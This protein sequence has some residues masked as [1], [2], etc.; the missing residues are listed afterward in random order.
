MSR[1]ITKRARL[2]LAVP[3]VCLA[4]CAVDPVKNAATGAATGTEASAIRFELELPAAV[5]RQAV[6]GRV[7][8]T[9]S[10][11]PGNRARLQRSFGHQPVGPGR[12]VPFFAVDIEQLQPGAVAVI[13]GDTLGYPHER[14]GDVPAGDYYV[15][16]ILNVYTLCKLSLIHL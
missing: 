16:A 2:A 9:L 8:L 6:T 11:D 5:H 7:Y 4:A 15:Q 14:P 12:G 1:M 3:L 13:D 10:K